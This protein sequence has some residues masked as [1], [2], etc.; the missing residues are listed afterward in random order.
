MLIAIDFFECLFWIPFVFSIQLL[1][2]MGYDF[3]AETV[4]PINYWSF[5]FYPCSLVDKKVLDYFQL[6]SVILF[7]DKLNKIFLTLFYCLFS[8]ISLSFFFHLISFFFYF[9]VIFL[10]FNFFFLLFHCLC[11]PIM[12]SFFLL[13]FV[14]F[15]QNIDSILHQIT[16]LH[17]AGMYGLHCAYT[18]YV[19]DLIMNFFL[20]FK[21]QF[22]YGPQN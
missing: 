4:E 10:L 21:H 16:Y 8:S 5:S 2:T 15:P 12:L 1:R 3:C 14:V 22:Q 20:Y 9:I 11:L 6:N 19:I 17:H 7:P 13:F 18:S